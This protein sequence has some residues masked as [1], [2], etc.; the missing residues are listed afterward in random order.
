M[1]DFEINVTG[2]QGDKEQY[3]LLFVILVASLAYNI[4]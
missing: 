3:Y 2:F 1:R 4:T